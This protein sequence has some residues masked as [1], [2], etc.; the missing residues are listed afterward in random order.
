M[1][2]SAEASFSM[3]AL[4][5]AIGG[6]TLKKGMIKPSLKALACIPLFFALQQLMEGLLWLDIKGVI[7]SIPYLPKFALFIYLFFGFIFW[8]VWIPY[9]LWQAE[10][11]DT[12]KKW[13]LGLFFLGLI[14][15]AFGLSTV[16]GSSIS[17]EVVDEHIQY[18]TSVPLALPL[19]FFILLYSLCVIVPSFIS[20]IPSIKLFGIL[21]FAS[22]IV[23]YVIYYMT[24]TS[25]WCFFSALISL[26]LYYVV[27]KAAKQF[28]TV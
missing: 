18:K 27:N 20:S 11:Q 4:L 28:K 21:S 7:T 3:A 5:G 1:C 8:P 25:V 6:F 15:G 9:S 23:A 26:S 22:L 12:R 13:L 19:T 16:P 24:F 17:L 14:V 2:F 10:E